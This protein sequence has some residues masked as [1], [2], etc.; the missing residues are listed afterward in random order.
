MTWLKLPIN[1]GALDDKNEIQIINQFNYDTNFKFDE[2]VKQL[3]R[4]VKK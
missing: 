3:K 2:E 1:Q 4:M